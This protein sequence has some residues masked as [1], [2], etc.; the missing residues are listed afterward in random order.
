MILVSRFRPTDSIP[1]GATYMT[2]YQGDPEARVCNASRP[3]LVRRARPT[4]R[5]T[6]DAPSVT[7]M[8]R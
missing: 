8:S 5:A 2:H 3:R 1:T 4:I 7:Y 6:S